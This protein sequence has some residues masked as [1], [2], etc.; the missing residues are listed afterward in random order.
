MTGIRSRSAE[1]VKRE[2]NAQTGIRSRS[3]E[4]AKRE[5]NA[6]AKGSSADE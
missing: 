6:P 1:G 3:A 4:G 5:S 2:S